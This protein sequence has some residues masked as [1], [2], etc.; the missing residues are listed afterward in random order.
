M[1][2]LLKGSVGY[3]RSQHLVL[4]RN[5]TQLLKLS[6]FH[7]YFYLHYFVCTRNQ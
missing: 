5:P 3:N 1:F 4:Y 7:L 2:V 6:P